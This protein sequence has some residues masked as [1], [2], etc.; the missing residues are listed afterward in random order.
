MKRYQVNI[1]E[2]AWRDAL[3]EFHYIRQR[4]PLNAERW[5][6]GFYD[7]VQS[8]E[9]MPQRCALARENDF[10]AEELR[11]LV[12]K[13]VRIVFTVRADIVHILFVR[14]VARRSLGEDVE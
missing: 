2:D 6:Q 4:A 7:A 8:L 9:I 1:D 14:H 5:L 10:F 12:F 3:E 13:P 11:Q